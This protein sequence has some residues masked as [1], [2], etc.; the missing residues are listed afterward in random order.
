M[1]KIPNLG[2]VVKAYLRTYKP[3]FYFLIDVWWP[4]FDD[5]QTTTTMD[6]GKPTRKL[7]LFAKK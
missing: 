5:P 1:L 2:C 6:E 3:S 4:A 7:L